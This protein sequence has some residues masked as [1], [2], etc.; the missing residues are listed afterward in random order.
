MAIDISQVQ[1]S[2]AQLGQVNARNAALAENERRR[3][4]AEKIAKMRNIG[5]IGGAI[6]GAFV[7][8]PAGAAVGAQLGGAVAPA[9]APGGQVDTA[10][11]VSAGIGAAQIQQQ[12]AAAA[13]RQAAVQEASLA[14]NPQPIQTDPTGQAALQQ[15]GPNIPRA[16]A[17]LSR[18]S[19]E[20]GIS[21]G[22]QLALA[23][24]QVA[25]QQQQIQQA[26]N[27]QI[28]KAKQNT[29]INKQT[30]IAERNN[31]IG[32]IATSTTESPIEA[33]VTELI[34]TVGETRDLNQYAVIA[35]NP[36]IFTA[37]P[38][39]FNPMIG[40][41]KGI[42]KAQAKPTR[43]SVIDQDTGRVVKD[44]N[45][46]ADA[47]KL[48]NTK[49]NLAV[50]TGDP[51]APTTTAESRAAA[52]NI[53]AEREVERSD[54]RVG[55]GAISS[56]RAGRAGERAERADIRAES[57]GA[58]AE[59][60]SIAGARRDDIATGLDVAGFL[61]A[62]R[63]EQRAERVS[64]AGEERAGAEAT[65]KGA[66]FAQTQVKEGERIV[67]KA[68]A[69]KFRDEIEIPMRKL[70]K[71]KEVPD[72]TM[73]S[74]LN[75]LF[76]TAAFPGGGPNQKERVL[77]ERVILEKRIE[78]K[79]VEDIKAAETGPGSFT[80]TIE[81]NGVPHVVRFDKAGNEIR[82]LGPARASDK[83]KTINDLAGEIAAKF[84]NNKPVSEKEQI[85]FS[86]WQAKSPFGQ[87]F[88]QANIGARPG[89]NAPL[90]TEAELPPISSLTTQQQA[91][92]TE[93]RSSIKQIKELDIPQE[94]KNAAI[95]QI[96]I[97]SGQQNVDERY[98]RQ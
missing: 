82:D 27:L 46:L 31:F 20:A 79:R 69:K 12:N 65:R 60:E 41:I 54:I 56:F 19:P 18:I 44:F 52:A 24:Q 92:V 50:Q 76:A 51:S 4:E 94:D 77:K 30:F 38:G 26:K 62:E 1:A 66:T 43:I 84:I 28:Q 33:P 68:E 40:R 8:G 17:A 47:T 15:P 21:G 23:G 75:E 73:L 13:E 3:K 9:A 39:K 81:K 22:I 58:R 6:A 90:D 97:L 64:R 57:A 95:L 87:L 36:G 61:R 5:V 71:R 2:L 53:R 49:P 55:F 88:T 83:I 98:L 42:K 34:P 86:V 91:F 67:T 59:R 78:A 48:A 96:M 72:A 45:N 16:I 63:A 14:L 7:G 32:G 29:A 80:A 10:G 89:L 93:S 70:L 25:R 74:D 85:I 37:D 11:V 35:Q